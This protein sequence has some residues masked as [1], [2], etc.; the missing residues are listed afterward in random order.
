MPVVVTSRCVLVV[1]RYLL[2]LPVEFIISSELVMFYPH[3]VPCFVPFFFFFQA[4]DG[5]RDFCLS[6]WLGD[7]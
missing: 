2:S 3:F 4:E 5:I 1:F 6:L 7:V